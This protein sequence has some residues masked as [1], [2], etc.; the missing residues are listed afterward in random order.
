MQ[1][2]GKINFIV[3]PEEAAIF[4]ALARRD[5]TTVSNWIRMTALKAWREVPATERS[6][7]ARAT[8]KD[9]PSPADA[10]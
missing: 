8:K 3:T 6:K 5:G 1:R 10:S 7:L 4:T 9:R 2:T